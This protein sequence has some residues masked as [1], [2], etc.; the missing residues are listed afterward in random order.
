MVAPLRRGAYIFQTKIIGGDLSKK[1]S[2]GELNFREEP[3][4]I[5]GNGSHNPPPFLRFPPF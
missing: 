1:L 2:C 3:M 4:N 5:V